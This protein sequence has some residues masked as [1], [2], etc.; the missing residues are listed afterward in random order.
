M[1]GYYVINIQTKHIIGGPYL[2]RKSAEKRATRWDGAAMTWDEY[3]DWRASQ[4]DLIAYARAH[5][6]SPGAH[7]L[8]DEVER[9][10]ARREATKR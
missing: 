1:S 7:A 4:L 5:V 3:T 6:T 8:L 9:G 10:R 2:R